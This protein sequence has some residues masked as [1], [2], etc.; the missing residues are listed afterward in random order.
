MFVDD[1]PSTNPF[2]KLPPSW[3]NP[4]GSIAGYQPRS[5]NCCMISAVLEPPAKKLLTLFIANSQSSFVLPGLTRASPHRADSAIIAVLI[6]LAHMVM[7]VSND[8][9]VISPLLNNRLY[10]WSANLSLYSAFDTIC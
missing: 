10:A 9:A 2:E 7:F 5:L 3:L 8:A 6:W 4:G 1:S